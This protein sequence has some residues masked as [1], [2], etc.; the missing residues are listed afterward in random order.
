M[1]EVEGVISYFSCFPE[2]VGMEGA[3]A[4]YDFVKVNAMFGSCRVFDYH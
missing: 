4:G 1:V 2:Y 3:D